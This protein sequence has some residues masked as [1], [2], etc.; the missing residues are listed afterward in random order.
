MRP[1]YSAPPSF[2]RKADNS[3]STMLKLAKNNRELTQSNQN[4]GVYMFWT[5]NPFVLIGELY[6][7]SLGCLGETLNFIYD[8]LN[9]ETAHPVFFA[10]S[11]KQ[12]GGAG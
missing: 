8:K 2:S 5:F 6:T 12:C 9:Y 1:L 7:Y 11:T 10:G 3:G 4:C